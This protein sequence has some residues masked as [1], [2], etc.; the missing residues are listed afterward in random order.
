MICTDWWILGSI[1]VVEFLSSLFAGYIWGHLGGQ[2]TGYRLGYHNGGRDA[3]DIPV[4]RHG[5]MARFRE[6]MAKVYYPICDGCG[7]EGY[8]ELD[9]DRAVAFLLIES[10]WEEQGDELFCPDCWAEREWLDE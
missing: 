8:A 6:D 3:Q 9:K 10:G 7:R 5:M 4:R 1:A 2:D